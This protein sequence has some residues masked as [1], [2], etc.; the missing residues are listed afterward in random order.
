MNKSDRKNQVGTADSTSVRT[1][2]TQ[3]VSDNS[4]VRAKAHDEILALG[5]AAVVSLVHELA[6]H[7]RK[8]RQEAI[9]ILTEL[10]VAWKKHANKEIIDTLVADIASNDGFV[11][12]EARTALISIGDEAVPPLID[13][14]KSHNEL[15]RWEAAK[16]LG[17]IN[18][19]KSIDALINALSDRMFDVRWLAAEGLISMGEKT[20]GPLLQALIDNPKSV[21]LH[22][23]AHH[24]FHDIH[25]EGLKDMLAPVIKAL[26][27]MD[28]QIEAPLAAQ[29]A[30]KTLKS[31]KKK[32]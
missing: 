22:E 32:S 26:E 17:Q 18:D 14:L 30:L 25:L 16:A 24:V 3:L 11:R 1:L 5:E 19:P 10:K 2:L 7:D 20:V 15:T 4:K 8:I 31:S 12:L 29:T 13:S 28:A 6:N 9:K 27:D 21:L 23:G